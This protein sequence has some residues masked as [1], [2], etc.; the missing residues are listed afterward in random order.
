MKFLLV[1]FLVLATV[2]VSF[3]QEK[4]INTDRPNI[5][6]ILADDLG[7]GD[8]KCYGTG[9]IPTPN[10]DKIADEG[11]IFTDAHSPS[12]VCTPTRYGILTGTYAWGSW[13]KNW[14]LM[15][16]M[17][18]LI[19][20]ETL[21]IQQLLKNNGYKTGCIG[22]WHLGWG[23]DINPNWNDELKPGPLETGFD[24]FFGVPFSHNSSPRLQGYVENRKVVEL[25]EGED[26]DDKEVLQRIRRKLNKT[27]EVLAEKA[28][29]F[30]QK[31]KE[32]PFFLYF[33]TTNVHTPHTPNSTFK[34]EYG[35]YG[36]F[37]QEF[38]W[39]VGRI[40]ETL[41][42]EGIEKNTL[43]IITSDNGAKIDYGVNEHQ[44]N[45]FLRGGKGEVFEGGHRIPFIIKWSG[46]INA[47][48][49]E[50][51]T[52]CL[53][54]IFSTVGG[55]LDI[56]KP[57]GVA[58]DSYDF[59]NILIDKSD[60]SFKRPPVI[61]HSV[62]GMFAIRDGDWKLI[63][64]LGNGFPVDWP[65]TNASGIGKPIRDTITGRFEDLVYYFPPFPLPGKGEPGGQLYNLETDP[66]EQNNLYLKNPEKVSELKEKLRKAKGVVRH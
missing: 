20:K 9:K 6:L 11:L 41:K 55:I 19:S 26:I 28:V 66:R 27:A 59:S 44:T 36:A 12:S 13:M 54:D 43:I 47:G 65:K 5:I 31:N 29:S 45:G 57:D 52:I 32:R 10:C 62:A 33:P 60:N 14:V 24:Y 42:Q 38:D 16:H 8:L 17:P 50:D 7:Y 39:I 53:T 64:G 22:K 21:T 30:I 48:R 25:K 58:F 63:D 49:K 35:K 2:P 56:E 37:V 23:E 46:R 4:H 18:L 61:H 15:E 40:A 3:S 51:V 34:S 1:V